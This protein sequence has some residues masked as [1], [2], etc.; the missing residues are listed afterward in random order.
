MADDVA[1]F[2]GQVETV[3]GIYAMEASNV[4]NYNETQVYAGDNNLIQLEHASKKHSQRC[5]I[6]GRKIGSLVL[7]VAADGLVFMSV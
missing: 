7:F 4:V 2:I 5:G 6:K 1:E 3:K